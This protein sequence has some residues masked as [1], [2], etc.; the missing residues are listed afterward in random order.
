MTKTKHR[1]NVTKSFWLINVEKFMQT[2][3]PQ[4]KVGT[5]GHFLQISRSD[6][7]HYQEIFFSG[8]KL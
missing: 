7:Q 6:Q 1:A 2:F 8:H 5:L 3:L 4:V